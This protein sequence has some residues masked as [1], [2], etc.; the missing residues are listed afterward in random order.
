MICA[1]K[2]KRVPPRGWFARTTSAVETGDEFFLRQRP[3][4]L[5]KTRSNAFAD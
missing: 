2:M 5:R 4:G 3:G 1:S